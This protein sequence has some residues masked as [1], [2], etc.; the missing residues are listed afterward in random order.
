MNGGKKTYAHASDILEWGEKFYVLAEEDLAWRRMVIQQFEQMLAGNDKALRTPG[1][2][3]VRIHSETRLAAMLDSGGHGASM[4]LDVAV[5]QAICD[6]TPRLA[7]VPSCGVAGDRYIRAWL[8]AACISGSLALIRLLTRPGVDTLA[9]PGHSVSSRGVLRALSVTTGVFAAWFERESDGHLPIT[10]GISDSNAHFGTLCASCLDP[11][12]ASFVREY[13][14]SLTRRD[15]SRWVAPG[16]HRALHVALWA[17]DL[18]SVLHTHKPLVGR[19]MS[20]NLWR[21]GPEVFWFTES[22]LTLR[23]VYALD[24]VHRMRSFTGPCSESVQRYGE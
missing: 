20:P 21:V 18:D 14:D 24:F 5:F 17:P 7:G 8:H 15:T 11:Y 19:E 22:T 16:L 12:G 2:E 10:L 3:F 9:W 23:Q 1:G 6:A 13:W 4:K